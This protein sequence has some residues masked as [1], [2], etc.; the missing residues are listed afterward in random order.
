MCWKWSTLTSEAH[1]LSMTCHVKWCCTPQSY[2]F[3]RL[4]SPE[5]LRKHVRTWPVLL[6]ARYGRAKEMNWAPLVSY[7]TATRLLWRWRLPVLQAKDGMK[8]GWEM[9]RLWIVTDTSSNW[10]RIWSCFPTASM[11]GIDTASICPP[12][13]QVIWLQDMRQV[14]TVRFLVLLAHASEFQWV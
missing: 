12:L 8:I 6:A 14:R 4:V 11:P 1:K 10:L 2:E 3:D 7:R 9:V 13:T 5:H